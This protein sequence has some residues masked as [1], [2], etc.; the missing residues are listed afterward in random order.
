MDIVRQVGS[1]LASVLGSPVRLTLARA[2]ESDR[3]PF[4]VA[5]FA[6]VPATG[7]T[8]LVTLGLC[9]PPLAAPDGEPV[10]QELLLCA[11]NEHDAEALLQLLFSIGDTVRQNGESAD[12]GDVIDLATSFGDPSPFPTHAFLYPPVYH[13]ET[14]HDCPVQLDGR[15]ATVELVWFIPLTPGEA[16]HVLAEGPKAFADLMAST[17]PDLL[18][19]D[20]RDSA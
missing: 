5:T 2:P 20:R 8:T 7:A 18:D 17:D 14:I 4:H 1:H 15:D 13:P 12:F 11:W 6:N 9:D 19:L 16:E 3:A 10:R